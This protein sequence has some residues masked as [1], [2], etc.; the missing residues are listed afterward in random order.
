MAFVLWSLLASTG[1][2]P[3]SDSSWGLQLFRL[4]S[5]VAVNRIVAGVHFTVDAAAGEVLGLTLGQYF[6]ARCGVTTG[7]T[8]WTFTGT[9]FPDRTVAGAA[10][11]NDGDF[12]W[13]EFFDFTPAA[14]GPPGQTNRP[15]ATNRGAAAV[16]VN[17]SPILQ[18]LWDQ[19]AGEW[20]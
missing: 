8:P 7:Y 10:P 4:A 18:W 5:R 3:Y 11:P 2:G 14:G 15:Y 19:A 1:V 6:L 16:N 9:G 20:P 12:Y 17:A 13:T